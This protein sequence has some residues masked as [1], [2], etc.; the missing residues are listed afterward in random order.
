MIILKV[1]E[2]SG[3]EADREDEGDTPDARHRLDY[4]IAQLKVFRRIL[5]TKWHFGKI[6]KAK[7]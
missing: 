1:K 5:V 7:N 2:K 4:Y 3:V 6:N